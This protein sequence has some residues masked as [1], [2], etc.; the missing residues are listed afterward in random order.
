MCLPNAL[1]A[2]D[3]AGRE[4]LLARIGAELDQLEHAARR[5]ARTSTASAPRRSW[6]DRPGNA[7]ARFSS[8]ICRAGAVHEVRQPA[9]RPADPCAPLTSR[10][11]APAA[12]GRAPASTRA[13]IGIEWHETLHAAATPTSPPRCRQAIANPGIEDSRRLD[14]HLQRQKRPGRRSSPATRCSRTASFSV[15][16]TR[17][18]SASNA[19]RLDRREVLCGEPVVIAKHQLVARHPIL[20]LAAPRRNVPG[21]RCRRPPPRGVRL[22]D[23]SGAPNGWT[24]FGVS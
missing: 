18:A 4:H 20:R 22:T 16:I 10:R 3:V 6:T 15:V 12:G 14:L 8:A 11:T 7:C 19:A 2:L 9:Q 23:G 17:S 1:L 24:S 21:A 13:C 5:S